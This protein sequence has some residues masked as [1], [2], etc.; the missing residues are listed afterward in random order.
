MLYDFIINFFTLSNLANQLFGTALMSAAVYLF[1]KFC[2]PNLKQPARWLIVV[3]CL[4]LISVGLNLVLTFITTPRP[5]FTA[6]IDRI[7]ML[8]GPATQPPGTTLTTLF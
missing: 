6:S 7:Y 1:W 5:R 3:G 4:F 8:P 2:W